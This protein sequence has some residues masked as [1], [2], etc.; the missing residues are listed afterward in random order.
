MH[1]ILQLGRCKVGYRAKTNTVIEVCGMKFSS[2]DN[3][4]GGPP[5]TLQ[6]AANYIDF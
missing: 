1:D 5:G 4:K 2:L 3:I 6:D